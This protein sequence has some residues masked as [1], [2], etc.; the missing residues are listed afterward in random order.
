MS[1]SLESIKLPLEVYR[2]AKNGF[3]YGYK[4][5]FAHTLALQ[6]LTLRR[7]SMTRSRL[8]GKLRNCIR[9]GFE[10]GKVLAIYAI[11][12]EGLVKFLGGGEGEKD[13]RRRAVITF[14]SGFT[15]GILVYGGLIN[16]FVEIVRNR[17]PNASAD[18]RKKH[19][20]FLNER[21]L[22]QISLYTLS[23][24]IM[25]VARYLIECKIKKSANLNNTTTNNLRKKGT[26]LALG[27][28]WGTVMMMYDSD[29]NVLLQKS[30]KLSMDYIYGERLRSIMEAFWM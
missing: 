29:E 1:N 21:I 12:Y 9:L 16:K 2:A 4:I 25:A 10:H 23:R 30:M 17:R 5:R 24:T 7:S 20:H 11:I 19:A 28:V 27:L 13:K 26:L 22:A 3:I 18:K 8:I 15:G 14:I 6:L